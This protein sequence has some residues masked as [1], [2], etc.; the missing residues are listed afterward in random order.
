MSLDDALALA[1]QVLA[2][3]AASGLAD[4]P[5]AERIWPDRL[6][7]ALRDLSAAAAVFVRRLEDAA[8]GV[9]AEAAR[10]DRAAELAARHAGRVRPGRVGDVLARMAW[11]WAGRA[12]R[13][14]PEPGAVVLSAGEADTAW[15]ALADAAAWR[16][17]RA[18]DEN[19]CFGCVR[20]KAR[21]RAGHDPDPDLARCP[22]HARN[23]T[24]VAD[25]AALRLR[26][27]GDHR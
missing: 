4:A 23:E 18:D 25:Y 3:Y 21:A 9:E 10:L 11:A 22:E 14:V 24:I 20:A 5:G 27:G 6:A 1:G 17:G 26:L 2:D 19:G 15:Q 8:A 16:A 13:R 7:H 12:A